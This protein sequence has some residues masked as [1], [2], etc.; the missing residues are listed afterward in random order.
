MAGR[1]SV[2]VNLDDV[3]LRFAGVGCSRSL[4]LA[5]LGLQLAVLGLQLAVFNI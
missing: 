1:S 5:A 3:F 4:Q 2:G